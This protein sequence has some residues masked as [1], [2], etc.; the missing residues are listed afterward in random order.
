LGI[1]EG[2]GPVK[3]LVSTSLVSCGR[4]FGD[5][6]EPMQNP[7]AVVTASHTP[8]EGHFQVNQFAS[9]SF[10]NCSEPQHHLGTNHN[11]PIHL[12]RLLRLV[13]STSIV[14]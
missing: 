6:A 9:F 10:C 14:I 5:L 7:R 12:G 3:N 8:S 4:P 1:S 13:L 2:I 11:T